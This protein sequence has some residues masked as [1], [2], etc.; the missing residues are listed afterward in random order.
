MAQRNRGRRE[1]APSPIARESERG[2]GSGLAEVA[3]TIRSGSHRRVGAN[4]RAVESD[5]SSSYGAS[6]TGNIREKRITARIARRSGFRSAEKSGD[7]VL[8]TRTG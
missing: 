6:R 5:F 4:E 8:R 2:I 1:Q 7:A 3:R